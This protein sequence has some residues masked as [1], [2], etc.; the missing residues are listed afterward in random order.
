MQGSPHLKLRHGLIRQLAVVLPHAHKDC[1]QLGVV[2]ADAGKGNDGNVVNRMPALVPVLN[3]FTV[4]FS[5]IAIE[6]RIGDSNVVSGAP[7]LVPVLDL[8]ALR[9]VSE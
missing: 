6:E 7:T 1:G 9:K 5:C 2:G 8:F 4:A 3:L